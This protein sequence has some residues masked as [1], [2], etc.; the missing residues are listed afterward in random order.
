MEVRLL[1]AD[2]ITIDSVD[3]SQ[4]QKSD[5]SQ[6][7][8]NDEHRIK[9]KCDMKSTHFDLRPRWHLVQ[10]TSSAICWCEHLQMLK[11]RSGD[12]SGRLRRQHHTRTITVNVLSPSALSKQPMRE[13]SVRLGASDGVARQQSAS[14]SP[15]W[16]AASMLTSKH[17]TFKKHQLKSLLQTSPHAD[18]SSLPAEQLQ[19]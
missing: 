3:S 13:K 9:D 12:A 17:S 18:S 5:W 14:R 19:L 2:M 6:K 1:E 10:A 7:A 15:S 11:S 8:A 16:T 4:E